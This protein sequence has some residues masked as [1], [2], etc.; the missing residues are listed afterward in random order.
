MAGR[1]TVSPERFAGAY[2]LC[3]GFESVSDFSFSF[4]VDAGSA[5]AAKQGLREKCGLK[6]FAASIAGGRE[7]ISVHPEVA[8]P[9]RDHHQESQLLCVWPVT[10]HTYDTHSIACAG[11]L[12]N[13]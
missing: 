5:E 7:R 9:R 13:A 6:V 11:V 2:K 3:M 10:Q 4:Q 12:R 1:G 8:D